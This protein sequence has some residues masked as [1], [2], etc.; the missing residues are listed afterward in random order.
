[1]QEV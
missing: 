1:M